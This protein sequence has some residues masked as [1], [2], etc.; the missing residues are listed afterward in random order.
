MEERTE[1]GRMFMKYW[2]RLLQ[3]FVMC[4]LSLSSCLN[5]CMRAHAWVCIRMLSVYVCESPHE[6][7]PLYHKNRS[8]LSGCLPV[9]ALSR[10]TLNYYWSV[11]VSLSSLPLSLLFNRTIFQRMLSLQ[12]PIGVKQSW[13]LLR[14]GYKMKQAAALINHQAVS[15]PD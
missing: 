13:E 11:C 3:P 1:R 9:P 2:R 6:E 8:Q 12:M 5:A 10:W 14:L 4:D 15:E 7:M